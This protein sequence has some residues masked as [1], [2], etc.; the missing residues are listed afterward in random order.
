MV[1]VDWVGH[2]RRAERAVPHAVQG[3][4]RKSFPGAGLGL[5]RR[6]LARE[7]GIINE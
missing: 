2:R 3:L 5:I 6:R 1:A 7:R 4:K